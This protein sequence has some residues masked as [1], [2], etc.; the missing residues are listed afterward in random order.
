V[1]ALVA[2]G[3]LS[4]S[5]LETALHPEELQL[6]E[7]GPAPTL[8]YPLD[9]VARLNEL[10]IRESGGDGPKVM[11]ELGAGALELLLHGSGSRVFL[12]GVRKLGN[13]SGEKLVQLARL[14]LNFGEWNYR[15]LSPQHAVIEASQ[16]KPLPETLRFAIEGLIEVMAPKF[17]GKTVIVSSER[18]APDRIFFNSRAR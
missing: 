7:Q 9:S 14:L 17:L 8:W 16:V 6:L 10:L 2:S 1:N 12:D 11:R 4:Q 3:R 13:H 18:P 15:Q 5:D